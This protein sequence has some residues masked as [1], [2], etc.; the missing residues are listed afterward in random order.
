MD[1]PLLTDLTRLGNL[2]PTRRLVDLGHSRSGIQRALASG[3]VLRP[4]RGWIATAQA[5]QLAVTAVVRGGKLTSATALSSMQA[6]DGMSDFVHV[7]VSP[8]R[9]PAGTPP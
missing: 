7:N 5:S 4:C 6:W 1:T 2:A 3:T 9:R 8:H